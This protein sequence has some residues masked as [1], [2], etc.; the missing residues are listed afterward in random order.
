MKTDFEARPVYVR[1]EGR[2]QAHFPVCFLALLFY[3]VLE[4]KLNC[5]YTCSEILDTLRE[6]EFADI[7]GTGVYAGL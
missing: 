4:K 2:I 1:R 6:Y 7:Q 3:R 5:K